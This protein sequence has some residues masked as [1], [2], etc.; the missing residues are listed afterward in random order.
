[1]RETPLD[2]NHV[3]VGVVASN[4]VVAEALATSITARG[5]DAQTQPPRRPHVV[6]IDLRDGLRDYDLV[7]E[8]PV[9]A[10]LSAEIDPVVVLSLGYRGYLRPDDDPGL[11][12][13]ALRALLEGDVWAERSVL[14]ELS[15]TPR[16]GGPT[17]RE[18]Q[19]LSLVAQGY[20][21]RRISEELGITVSTVKAHVTSLL[22]KYG[23]QSRLEL[24]AQLYHV[25]PRS[26]Y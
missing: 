7:D 24:V 8:I 18:R 9:L 1:M 3:L 19:V 2:R 14:R 20:S 26:S 10:L 16:P 22:E 15:L 23:V 21:N 5:F 13:R 17:L 12:P 25:D 6:V 11:L 4:R